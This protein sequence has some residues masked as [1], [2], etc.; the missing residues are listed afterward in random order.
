MDEV[1]GQGEVENELGAGDED[2]K[3]DCT[4]CRAKQ[5]GLSVGLD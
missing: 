2:E 4:V 3:A 1:D 5:V